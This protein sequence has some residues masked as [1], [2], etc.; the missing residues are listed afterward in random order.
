MRATALVSAILLA[1]AVWP[2]PDSS[3]TKEFAG[4]SAK[5]RNRIAKQ[6]QEEARNDPRFIA[7]MAE[8]DAHFQAQRYEEALGKYAEARRLR[9]LNVFPKVRI[10]DLQAL[11][12]KR[13]AEQQAEAASQ[14]EP[15]TLAPGSTPVPAEEL[16]PLPTNAAEPVGVPVRE[17]P[18]TPA[19]TTAPVPRSAPAARTIEKKPLP[20][21]VK[22][23][24]E[25]PLADGVQERS[26]IEGRAVVLERVVTKDG[27]TV[28][29]RK[30]THPWGQVIHFRDGLAISEREWIEAF[31]ER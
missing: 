31:P 24:A 5:E 6:E 2:Q 30:V 1:G 8:A 23:E 14:P 18:A 29:Y 10:Q 3:L 12:A 11:L 22:S 19:S 13:A 17:H 21:P 4:M 28:A 16:R 7:V 9:P 15:E 27:L 26:F 20:E 25:P